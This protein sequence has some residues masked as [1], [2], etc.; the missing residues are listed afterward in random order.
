MRT[1]AYDQHMGADMTTTVPISA[2]SEIYVNYGEDWFEDR[3]IDE[4]FDLPV[5]TIPLAE[6]RQG[7]AQCLSHLYVEQSHIPMAGKGVFSKVSYKTGDTVYISPVA[8]LP[9]QLV[10]KNEDTNVLINYCIS[11]EGSDAALLPIALTGLLNHGGRMKS[12][13]RMEW[14]T[15]EGEVSRLDLPIKDLEAMP[16]APLDIRYVA[17]RH[18]PKGEELL[19]DYGDVWALK[20]GEHLDRLIE[21]NGDTEWSADTIDNLEKPSVTVMPQFREA[22]GVPTGFF[23]AH[24]LSDCIGSEEACADNIAPSEKKKQINHLYE[25]SKLA[26]RDIMEG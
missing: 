14:Y 9:K 26:M 18:I 4:I 2:G 10:R 6:L 22:I 17:T 5:N 25:M 20:W 23:P 24:F 16:F 11:T 8:I 7:E 1:E 12:N 21:W 13:I 19:L 15:S 3:G